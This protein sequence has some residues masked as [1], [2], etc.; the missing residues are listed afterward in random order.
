VQGID[1]NRTDAALVQGLIDIGHALDVVVVAEG[2]ETREAWNLLA[3]WGCD[4]AQG[5]YAATPRPADEL[6]DW[7]N[8]SWPAVASRVA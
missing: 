8:Q 2:V 7:L 5:Y 3:E 1:R 6:V 4:L